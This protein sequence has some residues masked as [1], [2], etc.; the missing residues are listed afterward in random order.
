[1][2]S[3]FPNKT[4]FSISST[5]DAAK[6]VTALSNANPGV[7]TSAAHGYTAGDILLQSSGWPELSDRVVR[8]ANP[9]TNTFEEEGFDTTSLTRF[10]AGAGVGTVKKVSAWTALS[11]VTDIATSGGEQQ[12][13]QWVYLET[14]L[15]QQ[16]P[17]FKNARSMQMTLD[18][19]NALAWYNQL[20]TSDLTGDTYVL[21]AALPN[22]KLF[23]WS[24]I[25]GF[26]GE[27][28]WNTNQNMQV[29]ATFSQVNPR[30]TKY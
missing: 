1:M 17:T 23:Y 8:V 3:L 6:S 26:D 14:G 16:R 25:V 4:I 28:S 5:I 13:F 29:V 21:R 12:Y 15:Q 2:S 30:S 19:D 11:Q 27:P 18:Y 24:V 7:A 20:L 22:G 10:P 9:V